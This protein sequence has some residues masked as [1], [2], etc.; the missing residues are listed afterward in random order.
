VLSIVDCDL[1]YRFAHEKLSFFISPNFFYSP[2]FDSN[3]F[4]S[5]KVGRKFGILRMQSAV[6]VRS[7]PEEYRARY[8]IVRLT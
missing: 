1:E 4:D 8:V 6:G 3:K 5:M 7:L 2:E